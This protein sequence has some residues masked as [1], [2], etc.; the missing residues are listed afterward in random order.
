MEK[1]IRMIRICS[2]QYAGSAQQHITGSV[3]PGFPLYWR[4]KG[5][6]VIVCPVPFK[7]RID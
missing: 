5:A 2:L 4:I 1:R 3:C 6:S 7:I